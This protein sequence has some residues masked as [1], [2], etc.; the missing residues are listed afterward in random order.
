MY[1][2][3]IRV[4]RFLMNNKKNYIFSVFLASKANNFTD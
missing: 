1:F 2:S 3:L 4:I